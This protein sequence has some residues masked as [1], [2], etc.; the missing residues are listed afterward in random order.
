MRDK[1]KTAAIVLAAGKGKRMGTESAKQ[2]L[3][4]SGFPLLYY[5]L[6]VFQESF[7]DEIVLVVPEND[8]EYCRK[9]IVQK[10][11]FTKVISITAGGKE[12]YDSVYAGLKEI[13]PDTDQVFIHDAARPCITE[14]LLSRC[15]LSVR[16]YGSAVA[17][18]PVK[19]TI[20]CADSE[21]F[22]EST[23]DR[24]GLYIIQ[25]PQVFFFDEIR[26]AYESLLRVR[27]EGE[28]PNITDD[29]MVMETFSDRR[30]RLVE[31][32]YRNIKVTTKEDLY[33]ID[34][35]LKET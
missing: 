5:S 3:I 17:A 2:Y 14:E 10:Y 6:K 21:G 28:C 33:M 34:A 22:V 30:V 8:R 19:D 20:K 1:E 11:G 26:K 29:A 16:E 13:S 25:T 31:G 9:E 32:S 27:E 7:I 18:V 24:R 4:V 15:L 12:R 35:F 23:P